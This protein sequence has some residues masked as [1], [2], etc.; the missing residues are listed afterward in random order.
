MPKA[1]LE[2]AR[3]QAKQTSTDIFNGINPRLV[4]RELKA[5][6]TLEEWFDIYSQDRLEKNRSKDNDKR[7]YRE[8]LQ[9][10]LGSKLL[11]DITQDD[12]EGI[13]NAVTQDRGPYAAN[14][15]LSLAHAILERAFRK[16]KLK[17]TNPAKGVDKNPEHARKRRLR[18]DEM[19]PFLETVLSDP[20]VVGRDAVVLALLTPARKLNILSMRWDR[21]FFERATWEIPKEESKAKVDEELPL[22]TYALNVLILRLVTVLD[23]GLRDEY[24]NA[25]A[26]ENADERQAAHLVLR[27]NL[28]KLKS[29]APAPFVFASRSKAGHLM[30]IRRPWYR[31]RDA[32]GVPDLHFHDLRRTNAS[33]QQ[34]LGAPLPI[35]AKALGHKSTSQ[36]RKYAQL[37]TDDLRAS[38]DDAAK[39]MM[40]FGLPKAKR[41]K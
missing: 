37:E 3:A 12:I 2:G 19:K 15:L 29:D 7:K 14:R 24:E 30:D 1:S 41:K 13:F 39:A 20:H 18:R 10:P 25:L 23:G 5:Q 16:G 28:D 35:I 21:V 34:S 9:K 8:H 4:E 36:T 11:N 26:L 32:A 17:H 6:L 27:R 22:V 40:A 31:I 33:F 38:L